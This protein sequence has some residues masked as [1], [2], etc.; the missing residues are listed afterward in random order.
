MLKL[1]ISTYLCTG[2][3]TL[4]LLSCRNNDENQ[5]STNIGELEPVEFKDKQ[6]TILSS[7]KTGETRYNPANSKTEYEYL[8]VEQKT[9]TLSLP[10]FAGA[11]NADI[12][13]PGSILRGSSFMKGYY[14]PLVLKTEANDVMLSVSL[15]GKNYPVKASSKPV[16]SEIR[17]VTNE[18]VAKY[19]SEIDHSFVPAYVS[20]QSDEVTTESSFNKSFDLHADVNVLKGL[21]TAK[22]NYTDVYTSS[23]SQK[24]VMVKLD[25]VFYN[26]SIDPKHYSD[27]FKGSV[28]VKD[29]GTHEPIYVSSVDYGRVAY[30]LIETNKSAEEVKKVI[31]GGVN[32]AFNAVSGGVSASYNQELRS[33][34]SQSKIRVFIVGGPAKLGGQVDNYD[35]FIEFIKTPTI[36]ELISSAA[37]ISYKIR[38]LKDNTEVEV[39]TLINE[40]VI[41]YKEN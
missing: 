14:D 21:V 36:D 15:R 10:S 29:Y 30:L 7:T 39:K 3:V 4:S 1:K 9:H 38:R 17:T 33:W 35:K 28:D 19:K 2:L 20:Y 27:W 31:S 16:L 25:Q 41:N 11:K 32:V 12:I 22:F 26:A 13:F 6:P 8:D 18:L 5:A 37:P 40:K 23:K 24:Y 34:F